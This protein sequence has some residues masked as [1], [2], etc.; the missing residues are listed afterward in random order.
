MS[1]AAQTRV[2]RLRPGGGH[3]LDFESGGGQK[4]TFESGGG[5]GL[6]FESGGGHGLNSEICARLFQNLR[7]TQTLLFAKNIMTLL[8]FLQ[9][10]AVPD[11]RAPRRTFYARSPI[12]TRNLA[13]RSLQRNPRTNLIQ[14][15]N[16]SN[17]PARP[18]AASRADLWLLGVEGPDPGQNHTL[19]F[20]LEVGE[21]AYK[22]KIGASA[23][24]KFRQVSASFGC[25]QV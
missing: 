4:L 15:E 13:P 19:P 9:A 6:D 5:H 18:D 11:L 2:L 20:S 12:L 7:K 8:G 3:G 10:C 24:F 22:V 14:Q 21:R 25:L 1:G 23:S 16:P 17:A